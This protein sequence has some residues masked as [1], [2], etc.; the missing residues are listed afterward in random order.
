MALNPFKKGRAEEAADAESVADETTDATQAS[1][2]GKRKKEKPKKSHELLSS[3]IRESTP[4]AALDLVRRNENFLVEGGAKG[5]VILLEVEKIGG[6]SQKNR[7]DPTKGSIIELI[8]GDQIS[9]LA[10]EGMLR[11]NVFGIIPLPGT[12]TRMFEY[13]ILINAP[14]TWAL[15]DLE[16]EDLV[17]SEAPVKSAETSYVEVRRVSEGNIDIETAFSN[18]PETE[19]LAAVPDTQDNDQEVEE[20]TQVAEVPEPYVQDADDP[21]DLPEGE[22]YV[23]SDDELDAAEAGFDPAAEEEAFDPEDALAE[24]EDL[25]GFGLD[26]TDDLDG[27]GDDVEVPED[28]VED[29][30]RDV[31]ADEVQSSLARR[32][33]DEELGLFV[34]L[35]AFD[36]FFQADQPVVGFEIG[37]EDSWLASQVSEL[38]R[39]GN[40]EI[41]QVHQ[42]NVIAL[43]QRYMDQVAR[44]SETVQKRVSLDTEDADAYYG[45]LFAAARKDLDRKN[46]NSSRDISEQQKVLREKFEAE[47]ETKARAAA[48][49][50]RARFNELYGARLDTDISTVGSEVLR[51]N[52]AQYQGAREEILEMRRSDASRLMGRGVTRILD[53]LAD[54]FSASVQD[55]LDL[56]QTWNDRIL[57]F[58]DDNRKNDVARSETLA[59]ELRQGDRADVVR[60]DF[61]AQIEKA[62]E[63]RAR[64]DAERD[65][66]HESELAAWS[67]RLSG[68]QSE[69]NGLLEAERLRSEEHRTHA[70]NLTE[71]LH[72]LEPDVE[73]R[74]EERYR[75][76]L[77]NADANREQAS[78]DA[79][80][81]ISTQKRTNTLMAIV[82]PLLVLVALFVGVIIGFAIFG[83]N[84]PAAGGAIL[85]G[86]DGLFGSGASGPQG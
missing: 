50:A 65:R 66:R 40:A 82:V 59:E 69:L 34:D 33:L 71:R 10:T 28:Y 74:V 47:R 24:D 84:E 22:G 32:M 81:V 80:R 58:I 37:D 39:Q 11:D 29:D 13:E 25:G 43:G 54:E 6:L 12:L 4:G 15:V 31:S 35:E 63:D 45:Q 73:K 42:N 64:D 72:N 76:H 62:R 46:S 19:V 17:I 78:L 75:T 14:Y 70:E 44:H 56:H 57:G 52:D 5:A 67:E 77:A 83:G 60:A 79:E 86:V 26:E 49:D 18:E 23:P 9:T 68:T 1:M 41:E 8:N 7:R 30:G 85:L 51:V 48:E 55:E 21:L 16:S 27:I 53:G 3:V 61:V 2:T 36:A 38:R 20:V